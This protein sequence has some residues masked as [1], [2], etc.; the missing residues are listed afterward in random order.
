MT[1]VLMLAFLWAAV[2]AL[3]FFA[4]TSM[5][6]PRRL[7]LTIGTSLLFGVVGWIDISSI[8]QPDPTVIGKGSVRPDN[9][10]THA[11][12][13]IAELASSGRSGNR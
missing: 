11:R 3:V 1:Y 13:W 2:G 12:A 6:L 9:P 8:V 7:G 4:R 10:I 5:S